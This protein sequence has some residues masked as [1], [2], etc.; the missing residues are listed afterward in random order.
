MTSRAGRTVA[1]AAFVFAVGLGSTLRLKADD[2]RQFGPWSAPT[3]LG[4]I[5]NTATGDFFPFISRD[6]LSLYFTIVTC[7]SVP[8]PPPCFADPEGQGGWDIY[9]SRRDSIAMPWGVPKNLGAP[10]NTPFNE[11][12]PSLSPDGHVM[13]FA[14]DR[15]VPP[16]NLDND[17]YASRRHNKRFDFDELGNSTWQSPESLGD[18]VN[19]ACDSNHLTCN[20]S[21]PELFEDQSTGVITLYFDSN[22][23]SAAS[24]TGPFTADPAFPRGGGGN[25]GNDIY[26]SILQPDGTFGPATLVTELST[27]SFD[28][29]PTIRRDG[30]EMF[31]ASNRPGSLGNTLDLW[32]S[33]RESTSKPWSTPVNLGPGVNSTS[34]TVNGITYSGAD[35]GPALS[36]DS[37]TLYFQSARPG[38]AGGFDLHVITREK[39]K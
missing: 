20:E 19:T 12:A 29:H 23:P 13:F 14:S 16:G 37:K 33:T 5:V 26:T 7:G 25:N 8:N 35:A 4:P 18:G 2:S 17:I 32:M 38:N 27:A 3:N 22:R 10:V 21:S 1:V 11:G 39:L 9:V 34:V 6:G 28:R 30:L 36:F 31:L 15:G 24:N